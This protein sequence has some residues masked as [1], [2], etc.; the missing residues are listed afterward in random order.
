[1]K[2]ASREGPEESPCVQRLPSRSRAYEQLFD[3]MRTDVT[4]NVGAEADEPRLAELPDVE[5]VEPVVPEPVEPVVPEP[6]VPVVP[7]PVVPVVPEP[8]V[9]PEPV[10]PELVMLPELESIVP[11]TS[12]F[13]LTYWLRLTDEEGFSI[14]VL[15]APMLPEPVVP[16]AVEPVVPDAVEPVEPVVP[17]P[18]VPLVAPVAELP[19]PLS[20]CV[21]MYCPPALAEAEPA[22]LPDVPEPAVVPDPVVPAVPEAVVPAPVV[23]EVEPEAVDPIDPLEL[24]GIRQ[25]V[26]VILLPVCDPVDDGDDGDDV[27]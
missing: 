20:I 9:L 21:S 16:D 12:T 8:A 10:E 2:Q 17:E 3:T 6:V 23:P 22:A 15:C 4:L 19:E 11:V 1:M 25:P 5:P 27:P 24:A 14:R 26:T 13:W 18:V 7:E